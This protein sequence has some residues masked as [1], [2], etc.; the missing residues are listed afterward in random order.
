MKRYT[1]IVW[2]AALLL[3][4]VGCGKEGAPAAPAATPAAPAVETV[5]T[6]RAD[7]V[8]VLMY[9]MIADIPG[10]D[11]VLR[12]DLFR[13]Q[14]QYLKDNGYHPITMAQLEAYIDHDEPLPPKPVCITFDDGYP[15]TYTI[16][17]PILKEYG[18]PWTLFMIG[19][20]A[21]QPNRPTLAQLKEMR[22][23]GVTI[24]NHTWTHAELPYESEERQREEISRTQAWLKDELGID[25]RYFAYPVGLYDDTVKQVLRD[26]GI[27]VAV[28][29]NPGRVRPGDDPLEVKRI[30]IGDRVDLQHFADRLTHD[31]YR[32]L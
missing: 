17:Y 2:M 29:M 26:N 23:N 14:M 13:E 24:A 16:V 21:D 19:G 11:A 4:A 27:T 25:N 22:D 8:S 3:L 31:H 6:E 12:E 15:D 28:T 18:F 7:G 30:W 10:N 20:M 1:W 32:S 9:H 5:Q